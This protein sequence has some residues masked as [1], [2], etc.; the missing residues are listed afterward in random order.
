MGK[1]PPPPDKPSHRKPTDAEPSFSAPRGDRAGQPRPDLP[2]PRIR[3]PHISPREGGGETAPSFR[4]EPYPAT[5]GRPDRSRLK[6]AL[7][8]YVM[9]H[10]RGWEAERK[11]AEADRPDRPVDR[12]DR[13]RGP[14]QEGEVEPEEIRATSSGLPEGVDVSVPEA[15]V[16]QLRFGVPVPERLAFHRGPDVWRD[17]IARPEGSRSRGRASGAEPT[18]SSPGETRSTSH[19][20]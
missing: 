1:S 15:P 9:G 14:P 7:R 19:G 3:D 12:P 20:D 16:G 11:L 2:I 10:D 4:R 13:F 5:Y 18:R 17:R 6:R 8:A